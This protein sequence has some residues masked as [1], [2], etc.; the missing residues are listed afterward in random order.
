MDICGTGFFIET[1]IILVV[2]KNIFIDAWLLKICAIGEL[3][4]KLNAFLLLQFTKFY[5]IIKYNLLYA[6]SVLTM[7]LTL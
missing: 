6:C 7:M 5:D 1:T 3:H 4:S 2:K